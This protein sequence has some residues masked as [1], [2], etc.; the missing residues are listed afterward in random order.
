M[1]A[2]LLM[3]AAIGSS[4]FFI[5]LILHDFLPKMR[6]SGGRTLDIGDGI[7]Y[8]KQKLSAHPSPRAYDIRPSGQGETYRYFVD[9]YW[10]VENVLRD[11]R[12]IVTTRTNK[13]HY[14][15]PN[16][17]NLRKAGPLVRL[18]CWKRF[19]ALRAAA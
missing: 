19:P 10:T 14:L 9:K 13:H 7:V 6:T 3:A 11:G 1:I 4:V 17:P 12:I 15:S 5:L 2:L 16:D 8:R 18:R